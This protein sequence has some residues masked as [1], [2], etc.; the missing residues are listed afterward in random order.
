MQE[1][2]YEIEYI[3]RQAAPRPESALSHDDWVSCVRGNG[4]L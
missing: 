3:E 4:N 2:V 1:T